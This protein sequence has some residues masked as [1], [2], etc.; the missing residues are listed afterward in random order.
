MKIDKSTTIISLIALVSTVVLLRDVSLFLKGKKSYLLGRK[1]DRSSSDG[2]NFA[3]LNNDIVGLTTRIAKLEESIAK[4]DSNFTKHQVFPLTTDNIVKP[5]S[6]IKQKKK[7]ARAVSP[8]RIIDNELDN[9]IKSSFNI[10][11]RDNET[12]GRL[13]MSQMPFRPMPFQGFNNQYQRRDIPQMHYPPMMVPNNF[14]GRGPRFTSVV[15][16]QDMRRFSE[17]DVSVANENDQIVEVKKFKNLNDFKEFGKNMSKNIVKKNDGSD[18]TYYK[19]A[20][21][22][23]NKKSPATK[24]EQIPIFD[25]SFSNSVKDKEEIKEEVATKG[26]GKETKAQKDGPINPESYLDLFEPPK[27]ENSR[28]EKVTKDSINILNTENQSNIGTKDLNKASL[29]SLNVKG[30]NISEKKLKELIS[31]EDKL[32]SKHLDVKNSVPRID[33]R[34]KESPKHLDAQNSIPRI[35]MKIKESAIKSEIDNLMNDKMFEDNDSVSDGISDNLENNMPR[36]NTNVIDERSTINSLVPN[37]IKSG[38]AP[39]SPVDNYAMDRA[40]AALANI[41]KAL[42][43]NIKDKPIA[44]S[45]AASGMIKNGMDAHSDTIQERTDQSAVI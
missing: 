3:R 4:L 43:K 20:N 9:E 36:F 22:L 5:A 8:F 38:M 33:M 29:E 27:T 14:Y 45:Q 15:N 28:N 40:D 26:I 35:D 16:N 11:N 39:N 44:N 17:L 12:S 18:S 25:K 7:K 13:N 6:K 41:Q 1:N 42:S 37:E 10:F 32:Y 19:M 2:P 23:S 30:I 34:I 31:K 24:I 21:I